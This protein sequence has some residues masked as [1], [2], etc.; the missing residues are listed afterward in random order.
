MKVQEQVPTLQ[1]LL[2]GQRWDDAI[3]M[4]TTAITRNLETQASTPHWL[5]R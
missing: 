2:A 5:R 1:E 4:A 3:A